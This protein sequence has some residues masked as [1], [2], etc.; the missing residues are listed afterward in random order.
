MKTTTIELDQFRDRLDQALTEAEQGELTVTRQG[1]P[2]LVIRAASHDRD[3]EI[4]S[5]VKSR[6][7]SVNGPHG[8]DEAPASL[9]GKTVAWTREHFE[10]IYKTTLGAMAFVDGKKVSEDYVLKEGQVFEF[11]DEEEDE[12][13]AAEMYKSPEF[14]EMIR[15]RRSEEAIPWDVAMRQLGLD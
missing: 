10:R 12:E 1:K 13:W 5:E 9:V 4:P 6:H 7:D 14:W 2:W 15:Q 3:A 11:A 8:V